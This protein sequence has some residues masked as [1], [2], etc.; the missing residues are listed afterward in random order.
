MEN[1]AVVKLVQ[2]CLADVTRKPVE[3]V[4]I[5]LDDEVTTWHLALHFPERAP[6]QGG[7]GGSLRA[8]DFS[9]YAT[10]RFEA[11]F[12]ARPP[13]FKFESKW[14]NH[15]HLWG[16]RICHSLLSDDFWDF[17]REKRTHSTSLWNASCALA[18]GD[19]LGGMPRYLQILRDFLASDP[20]YEEEQHVKYDAESLANDVAAQRRF[21]PA[22]WEGSCRLEPKAERP[23]RQGY[24]Q[25]EEAPEKAKAWGTDF[26]LKTP[27]LP[28]DV[29]CHPCFEVAI[30]PGRLPSLNT[31][32]ACLCPKSFA[33]GARSSDFGLPVDA[34]LPYPCHWEAWQ[35]CAQTLAQQGLEK[36][37]ASTAGFYQLQLP[38]AQGADVEHLEAILNIVGEIWKTTCIGIVKNNEY[39]SERAMMCFVTLHFLLLCW[40][41]DHP[42]LRAHAAKSVAEFLRMAQQTP[43]V[44][45]KS[46]VPD[47]GR[48]L[49]R[50][51]LAESPLTLKEH[52]PV[53]VRELFNRNVRWVH[54]DMWPDPETPPPLQE[55][56][57]HASFEASQFGMKLLVFQSYYILRSQELG[58]DSM[59]ALDACAGRPASEALRAFQRDCREIKEM[60]SY[61]EFFVWLQ[62]EE[63]LERDLHSMLCAAVAESEERGY[64]HGIFRN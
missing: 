57:V 33:Q 63:F 32:M 53:L 16:D 3:N 54:P 43:V 55:L 10:L 42:A 23:A 2:R 30:V 13:K 11:D 46:C 7:P 52:L 61:P 50:F 27:V 60:G 4:E 19:G 17:F 35:G 64:N 18:D 56:E 24:P 1:A 51:L 20:D 34:I 14:I 44:N 41:Q 26:F 12:P 49:V 5:Y 21:K 39:E 29:E 8:S 9:L 38:S 59:D 28:G 48:F 47:L 40:D 37:K 58:L 6:F 45:L 25:P 22:W 31:S 62:L 36:L 15:Q